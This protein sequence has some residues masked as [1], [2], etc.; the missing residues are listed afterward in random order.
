M[1]YKILVNKEQYYT[2]VLQAFN[3]ILGLSKKE[4]QI[5]N[6]VLSNGQTSMSTLNREHVRKTIGITKYSLNNYI[7][8]LRIKGI[9]YKD[10]SNKTLTIHSGL[11]DN[12]NKGKIEYNF[13]KL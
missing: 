1:T 4:I 13:T 8:R 10:K 6:C 12:L 7:G 11:V 9:L 3:P 5:L 2:S